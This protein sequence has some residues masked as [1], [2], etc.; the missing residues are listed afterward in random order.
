MMATPATDNTH[1]PGHRWP[2]AFHYNEETHMSRQSRRKKGGDHGPKKYPEVVVYYEDAGIML[3]LP[4]GNDNDRLIETLRD[5]RRWQR[6]YQK[7]KG[8]PL[9]VLVSIPNFN[10]DPR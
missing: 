2:R 3:S 4:T 5:V 1:A 6:V 9:P 7:D 8:R 10:D